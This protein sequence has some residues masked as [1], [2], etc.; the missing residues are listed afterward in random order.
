MDPITAVIVAAATAGVTEIGKKGLTDAYET[1]KNKIAEKFDQKQEILP[2]IR[3]IE[4]KPDL[5]FQHDELTYRITTAKANGDQELLQMV[6]AL[7]TGLEA[8][9]KEKETVGNTQYNIESSKVIIAGH[10]GTIKGNINFNS[11]K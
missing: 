2:V 10:N 7:K 9:Q 6:Q 3:K 8:T 4:D 5:P 11:T 1:L